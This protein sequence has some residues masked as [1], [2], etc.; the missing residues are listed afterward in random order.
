MNTVGILII[1]L[2]NSTRILVQVTIYCS[3]GFV[4]MLRYIVTC[5]RI[6]GPDQCL[7]T[8]NDS[9]GFFSIE[10]KP[11]RQY[12]LGPTALILESCSVKNLDLYFPLSN[13]ER[14]PNKLETLIQCW[15]TVCRFAML[16]Q[17]YN[18]IASSSC[19]CWK[20]KFRFRSIYLIEQKP[21][22]N[23]HRIM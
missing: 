11:L 5:K 2:E 21:N 13:A 8:Q 17:H 6:R 3:L 9:F 23:L 12:L 4:E 14:Q 16:A 15:S 1:I 18:N 10:F 20:H 22:K 19:V 7:H